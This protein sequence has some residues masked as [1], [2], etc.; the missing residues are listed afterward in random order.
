MKN[1]KKCVNLPEAMPPDTICGAFQ[2]GRRLE[3]ST[4]SNP[5]HRLGKKKTVL[6][7]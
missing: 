6:C 2:A 5:W 7:P 4:I 3:A 1:Y